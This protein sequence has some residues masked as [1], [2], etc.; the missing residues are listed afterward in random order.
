MIFSLS[1]FVAVKINGRDIGGGQHPIPGSFNF[2]S[3]A[4][5]RVILTMV[6]FDHGEI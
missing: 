4:K 5:V 3:P 6:L 1:S 2:D